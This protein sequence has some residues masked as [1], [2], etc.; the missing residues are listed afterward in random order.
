MGA[1]AVAKKGVSRLNSM[2]LLRTFLGAGIWTMSPSSNCKKS[3]QA[4]MDGYQRKSFRSTTSASSTPNQ[5]NVPVA[6]LVNVLKMDRS[7][8]KMRDWMDHTRRR[9]DIFHGRD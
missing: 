1:S 6:G 3:A 5:A 4:I 7:G 8:L 9:F 2:S